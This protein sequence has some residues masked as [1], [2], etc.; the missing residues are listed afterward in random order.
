MAGSARQLE[1]AEY[2]AKKWREDE[3]DEVEMPEYNVLL[4]VPQDDKP[5]RITVVNNGS[6]VQTIPCQIE[7][8]DSL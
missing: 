7:V 6:I 8:R 4:S 1:L 5:N 3:F 2:L